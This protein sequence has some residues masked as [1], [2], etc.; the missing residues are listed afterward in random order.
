MADDWAGR[1]ALLLGG[2][3][4]VLFVLWWLCW[5]MTRLLSHGLRRLAQHLPQ[6][7]GWTWAQAHPLRATLARRWPKTYGW[8]AARLTPSR[9][10]GLPLT[11]MTVAALYLAALVVGLVE[12]V[13]EASGIVQ[14]DEAVNDLLAPYRTPLTI[15]V[16]AWF[17]DLGS[18]QAL[19]GIAL[20]STGFF[21]AY[22]RRHLLL[23]L[24]VTV[25]GAELTT[26]LGKF[27]FDRARPEFI[28]GVT[29]MSPSFPSGH[30]TGSMAVYGFMAYAIAR[31]LYALRQDFEVIYWSLVL[32]VLIGMSRVFLS[33]HYASDVLT[34]WLV[35]GFWLLVGFAVA[36]ARRVLADR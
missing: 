3:V 7:R 1:E 14:F 32:I 34:G 18:S 20:I 11:L 26:W 28:T 15:T 36:E 22:G 9:F 10:H 25:L 33:V 16:V 4:A 13:L 35:G 23:A 24:W 30:A 6:T 31:D 12:E 5:Q 8:L 29:A 19:V 21:W 2:L 27:A 17:T